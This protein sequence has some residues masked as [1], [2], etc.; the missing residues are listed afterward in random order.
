MGQGGD[1]VTEKVYCCSIPFLKATEQHQTAID[2]GKDPRSIY[3]EGRCAETFETC[4]AAF[5]NGGR[6]C[7]VG[8]LR[9]LGTSR[10]MIVDRVRTL[11]TKGIIPY[12][13]DSGATDETEL[14][15]AAI[16]KINGQRALGEDPR[17][18]RRIGAKGGAMKGVKMQERRNSVLAEE[19]VIRLCNHPKLSWDERASILGAGWSAST[20]RR[21]YGK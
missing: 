15:N 16:Q 13:M 5:R 11:K 12:D 6:L 7:L 18:P 14:L 1:A 9:V 3:V 20:L 4:V 21:K 19:I 8:G 10:V 17:R 2:A